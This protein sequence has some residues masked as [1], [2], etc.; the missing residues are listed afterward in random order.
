MLHR[1]KHEGGERMERVLKIAAPFFATILLA[2]LLFA[3]FAKIVP[4]SCSINEPSTSGQPTPLDKTPTVHIDQ[5]AAPSNDKTGLSDFL[6]KLSEYISKG[7]STELVRIRK[8]MKAQEKINQAID[9][10]NPPKSAVGSHQT[11]DIYTSGYLSQI[12][13]FSPPMYT[14]DD[15]YLPPGPPHQLIGEVQNPY[16]VEGSGP[17]GVGAHYSATGWYYYDGGYTWGEALSNGEASEPYDGLAE[18]HITAKSD[19]PQEDPWHNYLII[20]VSDD[21]VVWHYLYYVEVHSSDWQDYT[22]GNININFSYISVMSTCPGA[23]P[24][25]TSS[26]YVDNVYFIEYYRQVTLDISSGVGGT[27]DP[28]GQI[29]V[30]QYQQPKVTAYSNAYYAFDYWLIDS[31]T[32]DGT[33][34]IWV[35]MDDDHT[36]QAV[37]RQ[38]TSAWLSVQTWDFLDNPVDANIWIDDQWVG[39][40]YASVYLSLGTHT[41][42]ADQWVW[43]EYFGNYAEL[44]GGTGPMDLTGDVT[45][46][47][48]YSP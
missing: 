27:T 29:V 12:L 25:E 7:N 6:L 43:D 31:S 45:V 35:Y 42:A 10:A 44:V 1:D 39:S 4:A 33:N 8:E 14:P 18:F 28:S 38:I 22:I 21:N 15:E 5:T 34:P 36:I 3:T 48:Y 2:I 24:L 23:W 30:W 32:T 19:H 17:D 20:W 37:F 13:N 16:Y 26:V 40:G 11:L 41:I 9:H 46:T 47:V